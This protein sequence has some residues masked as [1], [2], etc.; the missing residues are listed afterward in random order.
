[1]SIL[2]SFASDLLTV[3]AMADILTLEKL[4]RAQF[5]ASAASP[6]A[7]SSCSLHLDPR[8]SLCVSCFWGAGQSSY[9]YF[10]YAYLPISRIRAHKLQVESTAP[11]NRSQRLKTETFHAYSCCAYFGCVI[12]LKQC[13]TH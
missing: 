11:K 3:A 6:N 8:I 10:R 2:A 12:I 1:M 5:N 9:E 7:A 4:A 13:A